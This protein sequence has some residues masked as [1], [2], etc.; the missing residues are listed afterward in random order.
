MKNLFQ[1]IQEAFVPSNNASMRSKAKDHHRQILDLLGFS[2]AKQLGF[3]AESVSYKLESTVIKISYEYGFDHAFYAIDKEV[4]KRNHSFYTNVYDIGTTF[5]LQWSIRDY[6][7]EVSNKTK[8]KLDS[9]VKELG[10]EKDSYGQPYYDSLQALS[11]NIDIL[12]S[13]SKDKQLLKFLKNGMKLARQ[14][15]V[16]FNDVAYHNVGESNGRLIYFDL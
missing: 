10:I 3:G 4:I 9:L 15:G 14:A 12:Q 11:R 2:K 16:E 6:V 13:S 8:K 5:E 7:P 1:H